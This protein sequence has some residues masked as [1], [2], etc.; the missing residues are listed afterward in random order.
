MLPLRKLLRSRVVVNM[1]RCVANAE[2]H[3]EQ[4]ECHCEKVWLRNCNRIQGD[5]ITIFNKNS[6]LLFRWND[7]RILIKE[8]DIERN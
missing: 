1:L 8:L 2:G 6:K 3:T 4:Q 5:L 7:N